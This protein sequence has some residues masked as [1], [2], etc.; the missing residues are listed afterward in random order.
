METSWL[1]HRLTDAERRTFDE[2][3]LLMLEDALSPQQVEALTS[4]TDRI[5][6]DKLSAGH[7]PHKALF[8]PNFIP[9]DDLFSDLVDYKKVLPKVWGILGW[10][11][12]LYHAH[13]I[14]TP[15]SGQPRRPAR[16][17]PPRSAR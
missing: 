10:N 7:D 5:Y 14:V 1:E 13:M 17:R 15:P 12:Y 9:D 11:I 2:T 6:R 8:Y 3:G 16:Q 4:A